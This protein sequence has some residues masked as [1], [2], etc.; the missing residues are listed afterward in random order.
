METANVVGHFLEGRM[1]FNSIPVATTKQITTYP[2]YLRCFSRKSTP[3]VFLYPCVKI[4][5]Q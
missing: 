3:M 1:G 2:P 5:L 4:P